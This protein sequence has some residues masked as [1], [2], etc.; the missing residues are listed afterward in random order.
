M[1]EGAI[2]FLAQ[3]GG[4]LNKVGIYGWSHGA[5]VVNFMLTHSN[6]IHA[7]CLGEGGDY[8]IA[9]F[10]LDGGPTWQGTYDNTFGGRLGGKP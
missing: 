5:F 7:A 1:V 8:S 10:W 6:K 3:K 2:D 9:N 4:D